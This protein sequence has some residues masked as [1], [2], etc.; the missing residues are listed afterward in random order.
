[1]QRFVREW[2]SLTAMKQKIIRKSGQIF[3]SPVVAL[4]DLTKQQR[5]SGITKRYLTKEDVAFASLSKVQSSGGSVRL[6]SRESTSSIKGQVHSKAAAG[7][8]AIT[9]DGKDQS[10]AVIQPEDR[11][12]EFSAPGGYL[13]AMDSAGN[14]LC[15]HCQQPCSQ[16]DKHVSTTAWD[17]RYCSQKCQDDFLIRSN[18]S[19]MR[20][21][22]FETE[23]GVC[24]QCCLN[25]QELYLSV[26]DAPKIQRKTL[27]EGTWMA[28]LPLDQ[29]NELIR[30]P[31]E[32]QFWQVDHI[33][34]VYGGGGQCSLDNLQTLC[35]VCHRERTAKQAKERSRTKKFSVANKH[36]SDITKFFTKV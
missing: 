32:G 25:A 4:G 1:M 22:V 10:S 36:S 23:H 30:N 9:Q 24:Q 35:T 19:Y 15:L 14:P 33:N 11:G 29:L 6:I 34:P 8:P 31:T 26:R 5:K 7:P 13:Q 2:N 21:K 12:G 28:Q 18:Q 3:V 20:A 17:T 16:P 27:L